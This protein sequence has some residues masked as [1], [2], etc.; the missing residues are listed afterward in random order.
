[1]N[2]GTKFEMLRG[3]QS[4]GGSQIRVLLLDDREDNLLLRSTILRQ[5][6]Y[7]VVTA[8]TV[9]EAEE[10][11]PDIDI[12]VLDYHLGAGKF[13][14][15]VA[16]KLRKTRPHVPI[17]ILSAT[18]ERT[19]GGTADMHL[20]KG[21]SSV[22]DLLSAL[23]SFRIQAAGAS[24][25]D[26]FARFLLLP[27]LHGARRRHGRGDHRPRRQLAVR[28]RPS[29]GAARASKR[30]WFVGKNLFDHYPQLDD[31]WRDSHP[32]RSRYPRETY[33]DRRNRKTMPH[34]P[35]KSERLELACAG[36]PA[37]TPRRH[38]MAS[39]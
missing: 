29:R 1:M 21:Q 9:E 11:L 35:V 27:H 13:G 18:L 24:R 23:Q 26:R 25:R 7:A 10:K 39:C 17:I 4:G 30:S 19:F 33:I 32:H 15:E 34:L 6:G 28:E 8:T 36:L 12:A 16:D 3:G 2:D 14:T 5:K 31:E 20:L 37:Q 22:D 38:R